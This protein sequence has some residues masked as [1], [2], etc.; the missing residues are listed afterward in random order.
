MENICCTLG[1]MLLL[2]VPLASEGQHRNTNQLA[3]NLAG[4]TTFAAPPEGFIALTASDEEL[5]N[6]GFPPRPDPAASPKHYASWTKA[7]LA[8]RKRIVPTLEQ[9]SIFHGPARLREGAESS[10]VTALVS[11]NWS[12]YVNLNGATRFGPSSFSGIAT[13]VVVP[14]ALEAFGICSPSADYASSWVGIDGVLADDVLQAGIE[15]DADCFNGVTATL[16]S[17]WIEWYPSSEIRISNLPIAPG[18]DYY[19]QVWNTSAT[20]GY[21]Y[22]VNENAYEAMT[23]SFTPP[24]GTKLVGNSAEWVTERPDVNGAPATLTNY[25]AEP[26]WATYGVTHNGRAFDPGSSQAILMFDNN[27]NEISYPTLLGN[28]AFL[29]QDAN[30]AQ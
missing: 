10:E 17:P 21:A 3:T 13:E 22:L 16:Y 28:S 23:I 19:V 18:D 29:T 27:G 9:T 12:G 15:F 26:F 6:F 5:S 14:T 30:T 1:V 11:Y 24:S 4:V 2:A 8:S 20:Q 25:I 7:M